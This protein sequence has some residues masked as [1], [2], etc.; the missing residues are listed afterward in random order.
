MLK[1][2]HY[3]VLFLRSG[4]AG[5][6]HYQPTTSPPRRQEAGRAGDGPGID[7]SATTTISAHLSDLPTGAQPTG[8]IF[9]QNWSFIYIYFFVSFYND[10]FL[11]YEFLCVWCNIYKSE[12]RGDKKKNSEM[13]RI[14]YHST[15]KSELSSVRDD[16]TMVKM[17]SL[18]RGHSDRINMCAKTDGVF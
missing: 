9:K 8:I 1:K 5:A 13:L 6:R 17:R 2:Q 3:T 15:I 14:F 18:C 10:P 11:P 7:I 4:P 12:L 16:C